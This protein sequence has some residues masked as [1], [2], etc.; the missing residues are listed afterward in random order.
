MLKKVTHL[1]DGFNCLI[2]LFFLVYIIEIPKFLSSER[3]AQVLKQSLRG[4][5]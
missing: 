3:K 5:Y 2:V 4:M 1:F